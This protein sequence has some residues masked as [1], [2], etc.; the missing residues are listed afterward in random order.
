MEDRDRRADYWQTAPED[1]REAKYV[2]I[3]RRIKLAGMG[4]DAVEFLRQMA[5]AVAPGAKCE[6]W[7]EEVAAYGETDE[8]CEICQ[9]QQWTSELVR[10]IAT[11]GIG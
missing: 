6:H 2:E 8:P 10:S 7:S 5:G 1:P 11:Q 9:M 3:D 4:S